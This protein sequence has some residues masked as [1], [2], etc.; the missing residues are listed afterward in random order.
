VEAAPRP[1]RRPGALRRWV[2]A[3]RRRAV[4]GHRTPL[5]DADRPAQRAFLARRGAVP[6][7]V[8]RRAVVGRDARRPAAARSPTRRSSTRSCGVVAVAG[9]RST[10]TATAAALCG[11]GRGSEAALVPALYAVRRAAP[12]LAAGLGFA[13]P[14]VGARSIGS[15]PCTGLVVRPYSLLPPAGSR[16]DLRRSSGRDLTLGGRRRWAGLVA[17]RHGFGASSTRSNWA[18]L[19][20][21]ARRWVA[22]AGLPLARRAPA[23]RGRRPGAGPG[24][25]D[26]R[27]DSGSSPGFPSF[28]PPEVLQN[29]EEHAGLRVLPAVRSCRPPRLACEHRRDRARGPAAVPRRCSPIGP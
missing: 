21:P 14:R 19:V 10:A 25:P 4:R 6:L 18:W 9:S 28:R 5:R 1:P 3:A 7:S 17:A 13:G 29:S 26:R 12:V 24:A 11:P 2:A 16:I 22:V 8:R 15:W 27:R 20:R 23:A